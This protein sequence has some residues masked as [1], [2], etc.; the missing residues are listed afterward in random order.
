VPVSVANQK[1]KV[2][3]APLHNLF[4]HWLHCHALFDE[5]KKYLKHV[6]ELSYEDYV[7]NPD[8]HHQE[9]A[10]FIGSRV[11]EGEMEGVTGT[12]NQK[13]FNRWSN[14][15]NNSPFKRYYRYIAAKYE[16]E[17]AKYGYSLI[18]GV[19]VKEE[20]LQ[21]ARKISSGFEN[22]YFLMANACA[23]LMRL[24]A[25]SKGYVKRQIRARLPEPLKIR[26]KR[27]IRKNV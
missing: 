6:Y 15:L 25:R 10:A 26:I 20:H 12:Y 11:P 22:L 8:K 16:P 9:I 2:S 5:D 17:F 3:F 13:Y 21:K 19:G 27:L 4:E 24:A 23:F 14:L 18:K 1:W 7:R